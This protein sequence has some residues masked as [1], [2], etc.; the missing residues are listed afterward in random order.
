VAFVCKSLVEFTAAG[1]EVVK[2]EA[3]VGDPDGAGRLV[4]FCGL[5]ALF[6]APEAEDRFVA[7]AIALAPAVA[8]DSLGAVTVNTATSKCVAKAVLRLVRL[9]AF[10]V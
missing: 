4:A 7:S 10:T 3:L 2:E 5:V 1:I 9:Y 8:V 6:I